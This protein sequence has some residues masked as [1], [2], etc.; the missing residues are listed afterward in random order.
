MKNKYLCIFLS[1]F[2]PLLLG[3]YVFKIS[4]YFSLL[5][6]C[7]ISLIISC[8][9][10]KR[11]ILDK[12]N[13]LFYLVCLFTYLNIFRNEMFYGF[14]DSIKVII[15]TSLFCTIAYL[16]FYKLIFEFDSLKKTIKKINDKWEKLINKKFLNKLFMFLPRNIFVF[17][18]FLIGIYTLIIYNQSGIDYYSIKSTDASSNV[19]PII[20]RLNFKIDSIKTNKKIDKI[21]FKVGTYNR[22]N[23]SK[24]TFKIEGGKKNIKKTFDSKT[25]SDGGDV[26]FNLKIKA[27]KLNDY[28]FSV[29]PSSNTKEENAV[30]LF[31]DKKGNVYYS[32]LKLQNN[33]LNT[34]KITSL[35]ISIFI[36]L[37]INYII[38]KKKLDAN[39]FLLL[40]LSFIIPILFIIP[41]LSVPDEVYHFYK[42]Y[43][44][45]EV[46]ITKNIGKELSNHELSVPKN[47]TCINYS[48]IQALNKV[49]NINDI[50]K[51]MAERGNTNI[52]NPHMDNNAIL[53]Y[54]PQAIGIKIA[55]ALSDSPVFIFYL[56]RVFS[57]IFSFGLIYLAVK[58]T[59]KHKNIF[60]LASTMMTFIQQTVSYSYDSVLH[61]VCILFTAYCLKLIYS[62]EKITIKHMIVPILSFFV[63]LNIKQVYLPLGI[64]L[65]FIPKDKCKNKLWLIILTIIISLG[66]WKGFSIFTN[67][68]YNAV[69]SGSN[70][71]MK[72]LTYLLNNPFDIFNIITNTYKNY[73]IFYLEGLIGYFGWFAFRVDRIYILVYFLLFLYAFLGENSKLKT[74]NKIFLMICNIVMIVGI[75]AAM[76][77]FWSDYKLPFVEGVQGRYLIP[78]VVPIIISL[79]PRKNKI[80]VDDKIIYSS[81][82]VLLLQMMIMLI[83]SYY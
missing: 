82:S 35:I 44:L 37:I 9:I 7:T 40:T 71:G 48:N 36:Y 75:F 74:I 32:L 51:C 31:S 21:C 8:Y 3:T 18:L 4:C 12:K 15:L 55:D 72:Q 54:I 34:F 58:I 63:M 67:I 57:L 45:S 69:S 41:P 64:M 80:K 49:Q 43:G 77:L 65:L 60:L 29:T 33:N 27:S 26:C 25:L 76:Y 61:A 6:S 22:I 66:L 70:E 13:I 59:P 68:G 53:G 81:I 1:N 56:G 5:I 20:E 28:N 2:L 47:I 78:L 10:S 16:F 23:D 83:I 19:G 17:I 50:G 30:T 11:K 62:K 73:F 38:N 24:I 79:I 46:D 52:Y 14:Y 42:S 39:K